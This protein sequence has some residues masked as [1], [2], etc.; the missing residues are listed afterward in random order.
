MVSEVTDAVNGL[1]RPEMFDPPSESGR[2]AAGIESW[3][4]SPSLLNADDES[5]A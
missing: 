5:D 4:D 1:D 2:L 3:G